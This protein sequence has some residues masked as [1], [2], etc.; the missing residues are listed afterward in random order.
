M[1]RDDLVRYREGRPVRAARWT[2]AYR[3]RKFVR[4]HWLPLGAGAAVLC[5]PLAIEAH[6]LLKADDDPV[7]ITDRALARGR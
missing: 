2:R 6:S 4:Q 1:F 5:V 7:A 3:L